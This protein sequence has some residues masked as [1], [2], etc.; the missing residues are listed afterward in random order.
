VELDVLD[1]WPICRL[2]C[3]MGALPDPVESPAA[4]GEVFVADSSWVLIS[5][6]LSADDART[7]LEDHLAGAL[8][9]AGL[10][11]LVTPHVYHL[12]HGS[13]V[14]SEI[15]QTNGALAVAG[16]LNPHPMECL[17]REY[18]GREVE[19]AIDLYE[20]AD[21][22]AAAAAIVEALGAGENGG[23]VR[24]IDAQVAARWYPVL[25]RTRCTSCA[26]CLQFCLFGVYETNAGQVVAVRPDNCKDGCPA[27]ARVCPE[28]AIMF[29]LSDEPAIAGAPGTVIE[30][31][32]AARRMYYVRTGK[33]CRVCGE[34][35]QAGE[36]SGVAEGAL[37][38]EECGRPLEA[39]TDARPSAV[40]QE[41][42]DL[43]DAL[44]DLAGSGGE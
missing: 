28:G 7:C 35:S 25:D 17:I 19:T 32:A 29:P 18:A 11:V 23:E 36:L 26:H 4:R 20:A 40:H 21:A 12:P 5:R 42:D 39:Q 8:A 2:L 31:D 44:D 6:H 24:E 34:V 10:R 33:P 16:W 30:P 43:I 27:C 3:R 1:K 13:D 37:M 22:E 38:C 15:A 9:E 41:I 14:W